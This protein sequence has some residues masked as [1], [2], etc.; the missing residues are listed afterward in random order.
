MTWSPFYVIQF[1]MWFSLT[2]L[3]KLIIGVLPIQSYDSLRH[4]VK[5][6]KLKVP[7]DI[8]QIVEPLKGND[9]AIQNYGIQQVHLPKNGLGNK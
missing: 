7:E 5:I 9:S 2:S 4:I 6:S 8:L 1:A 3:I